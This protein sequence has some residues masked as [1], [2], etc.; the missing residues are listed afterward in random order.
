[1]SQV[2]G[3]SWGGGVTGRI[4]QPAKRWLFPRP[5][6]WTKPRLDS[7]KVPLMGQEALAQAQVLG[8]FPSFPS[9]LVSASLSSWALLSS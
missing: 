4:G 1:M 7:L 9:E 2:D 5:V 8:L 6:N 3:L